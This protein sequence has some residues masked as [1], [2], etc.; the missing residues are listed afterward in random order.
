MCCILFFFLHVLLLMIV[1]R[2]HSDPKKHLVLH[3]TWSGGVKSFQTIWWLGVTWSEYVHDFVGRPSWLQIG[4]AV[5]G[6]FVL[7]Q[8]DTLTTA[9]I[10]ASMAK[11]KRLSQPE[12]AN[13]VAKLSFS[14]VLQL[15][16]CK[17][18]LC[19]KMLKTCCKY[20]ANAEHTWSTVLHAI[21]IGDLNITKWA[22]ALPIKSRMLR[23]S[24]GHAVSQ[25]LHPTQSSTR[26]EDA[27]C[28]AA[29]TVAGTISN[30]SVGQARTQRVQ[31]M[32]VS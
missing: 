12:S 7:L 21:S 22:V 1:L 13:H 26:G 4:G 23:K 32:Q 5:L 9:I 24:V 16:A 25:R 31:P 27:T 29:L 3:S 18:M 6:L 14:P 30:T 8:I 15:K 10:D 28:L 11:K 20:Y 19:W 2:S 17:I